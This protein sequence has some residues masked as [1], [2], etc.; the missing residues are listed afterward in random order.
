M[1][2]NQALVAD[3]VI[4]GFAL[5][6]ALAFLASLL[7]KDDKSPAERRLVFLIV[8]SSV[9][10]SARMIGWTGLE[11]TARRLEECAAALIG[12]AVLLTTEG[13]LRRHAPRGL[14]L[15][16]LIGAVVLGAGAFLRPPEMDAFFGA[17]LI[18]FQVGLLAACVGL[19]LTRP[20]ASLTSAENAAIASLGL[21][22]GLAVPLAATDFTQIIAWDGPRLGA[23]GMLFFVLACV[24]ISAGLSSPGGLSLEIGLAA[25]AAALL[26]ALAPALLVAASPTEAGRLGAA[27][28]A[29][30]LTFVVT[31]RIIEAA[32]RSRRR[33]SS[34]GGAI[35][36]TSPHPPQTFL[37]RLMERAELSGAT[38]VW[39][40][41]NDPTEADRLAELLAKNPILSA[42]QL[43]ANPPGGPEDVLSALMERHEASHAVL[44]NLE[45]L[46]VIMVTVPTMGAAAAVE[47]DLA[48]LH[49]A[50]RLGLAA[51]G[52]A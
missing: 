52:H 34:L 14:K 24:R 47:R 15:A 29:A 9:L 5:V 45:P 50:A 10:L 30:M 25:V 20:K 33:A 49:V 51:K 17:A 38:L 6:A 22:L 35:A 40:E 3:L 37:D 4:S 8:V 32:S 28:L 2:S 13:L 21:T 23:I 1:T 44:A 26:T 31:G 46:A 43:Q 16:A 7:A 39:P 36:N 41:T 42:A 48:H 18:A 11:N 12:L 27:F 19:V